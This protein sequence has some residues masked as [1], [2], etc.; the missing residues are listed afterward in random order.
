MF[1]FILRRVAS[2]IPTFILIVTAAFFLMR[3]APGSPFD[4]ATPMT[5]EARAHLERAYGLDQP[6]WR[7]FQRY[8]SGLLHGDLGPSLRSRAFTVAELIRT[9]LPVSV[10]LGLM[11]LVLVI[12]VGVPLGLWAALGRASW[13]D[14]LLSA[15][16]AFV[17]VLPTFVSGPVLGL[18]LGVYLGWLPVTGWNHGELRYTLL[19]AFCLALPYLGIVIRLVRTRGAEVLD[20]SYVRTAVAK[21]LPMTAVIRRHVLPPTLIPVA[22]FLGPAMAGIVVES[23]VIEQVF[24]IPGIGSYFIDGALNRDYPLVMG[25]VIVYAAILLSMN[26]MVDVLCAVLDPRIR[27]PSRQI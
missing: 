12:G 21:G 23:V 17:V 13:G 20:T 2:A 4:L 3:S 24:A 19:P 27:I 11:A 25:I 14:K 6:L 9:G 10:Q 1:P 16:A 8:V 26:I 22:S 15:G 5:P 18:I 7:Q